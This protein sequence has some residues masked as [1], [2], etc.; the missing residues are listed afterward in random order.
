MNLPGVIIYFYFEKKVLIQPPGEP[1]EHYL[2][3]VLQGREKSKRL[4]KKSLKLIC[5]TYLNWKL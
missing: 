2:C 4:E 5:V 3:D 1:R